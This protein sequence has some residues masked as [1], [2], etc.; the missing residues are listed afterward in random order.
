MTRRRR[1]QAT[2]ARLRHP[3]QYS[4]LRH[5]RCLPVS[6]GGVLLRGN[7][8]LDRAPRFF[9]VRFRKKGSAWIWQTP[10]VLFPVLMP[11]TSWAPRNSKRWTWLQEHKDGYLAALDSQKSQEWF[12]EIRERY[13]EA[14]HWSLPDDAD[15]DSQPIREINLLSDPTDAERKQ[16]EQEKTDAYVLKLKVRVSV[17]TEMK[18]H[19]N[20]AEATKELVLQSLRAPQ[21]ACCTSCHAA[22]C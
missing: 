10:T 17:L 9:I 22:V 6:H 21:K 1:D 20:F 5:V 15:P 2:P 8:P 7:M 13:F 11:V 18:N 19:F 14:F 12:A 16:L 4:R 3:A